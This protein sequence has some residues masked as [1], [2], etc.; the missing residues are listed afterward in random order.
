MEKENTEGLLHPSMLQIRYLT[1]LAKN[2]QKT[3]QR[4]ADRRYLRSQPWPGKP[5]F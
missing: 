4:G 1:E 5:L 3:R 2:R